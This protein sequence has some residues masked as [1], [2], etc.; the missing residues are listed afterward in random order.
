MLNKAVRDGGLTMID[1]GDDGEI[2]DFAQ[3]N[4]GVIFH[5]FTGWPSIKK[6]EPGLPT[7]ASGLPAFQ[8]YH[9]DR[10]F[11]R[12]SALGYTVGL[13]S[14]PSLSWAGH[15]AETTCPNPTSP[16]TIRSTSL[17]LLAEPVA[18]LP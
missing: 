17:W 16:T 9:Q 12:N 6:Q 8:A 1:M 7:R 15:S 13:T 11:Y 2:T 4:H 3:L 10:Q 14:R 18:I 5:S